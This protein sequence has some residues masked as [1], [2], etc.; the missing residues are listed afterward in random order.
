MTAPVLEPT[1]ENVARA[2]ETLADGGLVVAPGDTNMVVLAAPDDERAVDRVYEAKGRDRSSPL[3]VLVHD[4]DD[5]R[6]FAADDA[7]NGDL[8]ADLAD[9]L[10][11]GP[12]N[13]I[14]ERSE[15]VPAHVVSGL[16]TVC[17][18]SF[19]N[20]TWRALAARTGPVAATSAN[21]SGAVDEGLVDLDTAVAHLG[22]AVDVVLA[23]DRLD[24]TTTSTTIVDL[25]G[26]PTVFRQG[27]VTR[28]RLNAVRD[29]F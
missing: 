9:A 28:E 10:L 20:E 21:R 1:P 29:V 6:R 25:T 13:F 15:S 7:A 18:G 16:D 17:L 19:A 3:S 4:P 27:D 26:D 5:W 11:P 22:D 2:A 8:A 23:G 14:V 12:F 24:W